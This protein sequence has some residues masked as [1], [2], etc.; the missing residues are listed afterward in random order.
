M[1]LA[2]PP[3]VLHCALQEACTAITAILHF[4][5]LSVFYLLLAEGI[6]IAVCL[7]AAV[8]SKLKMAWIL[9][10]GWGMY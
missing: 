9:L 1:I 3:T 8:R 4:L 7:T 5:L 10:I 6:D 2:N